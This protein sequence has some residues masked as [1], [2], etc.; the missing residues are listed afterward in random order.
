MVGDVIVVYILALGNGG[1]HRFLESEEGNA[2]DGEGDSGFAPHCVIF[3]F[4]G[5]YYVVEIAGG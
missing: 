1:V 5:L 4:D 3:A 2:G